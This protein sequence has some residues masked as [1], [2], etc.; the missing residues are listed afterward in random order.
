MAYRVVK[1]L[2]C[3]QKGLP[4]NIQVAYTLKAIVHP[5]ICKFSYP[6]QPCQENEISYHYTNH[7]IVVR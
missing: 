2:M 3:G 1:Y 5:S 4:K 7:Y 6:L